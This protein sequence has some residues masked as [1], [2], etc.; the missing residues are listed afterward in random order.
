MGNMSDSTR[1][2]NA[3]NEAI[4]LV[5]GVRNEKYGHPHP[6]YAKVASLWSAYLG[7]VIEPSD[8]AMM[9]VLL[10]MAR[11]QQRNNRDNLVDAHGFLLVY[12]RIMNRE[13]GLE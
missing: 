7:V 4:D 3:A 2:P 8:A 12:E 5:Y 9:M 1:N 11:Q 13:A 6:V 10:K